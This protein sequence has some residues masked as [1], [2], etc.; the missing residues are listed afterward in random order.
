MSE[1]IV[2]LL[3]GREDTFPRPFLETVDR[4]G[5]QHGVRAEMG[6]LGGGHLDEPPR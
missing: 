3:V 4:K 5:A 1:K 2:G 6:L